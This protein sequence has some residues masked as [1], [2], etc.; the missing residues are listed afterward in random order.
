MKSKSH[1]K[2]ITINIKSEKFKSI[3]IDLE[4]NQKRNSKLKDFIRNNNDLNFDQASVL[5]EWTIKEASFKAI[6]NI[7]FNISFLNEIS[8]DYKKNTFSFE[9][10]NGFFK[11]Q[12]G[13][14]CIIAISYIK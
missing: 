5:E 2:N 12:K 3:G 11:I 14:N 10:I 4:F 7:G 8:V 13:N 6:S 9:N 1:S